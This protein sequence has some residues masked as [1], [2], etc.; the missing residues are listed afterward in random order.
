MVAIA[1]NHFFFSADF[2]VSA[3]NTKTLQ[4]RDSFIGTPYWWGF[5]FRERLPFLQMM[6]FFFS[7]KTPFTVSLFSMIFF[8]DGSRGG[9]VRN[10]EG[11]S[12]WLQGWYLVPW[13]HLN[14][15]RTDRAPQPRDEPNASFAQNSKIGSSISDAAI[16]LVSHA[17][18]DI[19]INGSKSFF[20]SPL[21][22]SY[23]E[24]P[25]NSV[26]S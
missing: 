9:D 24:G 11:P 25:Q 3:K 5:F 10:I 6:L 22:S 12:V 2:G 18:R 4:R 20:C 15:T 23:R 16:S 13:D 14:W 7:W 1:L 8:Q 21:K 26:I 19:F 17:E